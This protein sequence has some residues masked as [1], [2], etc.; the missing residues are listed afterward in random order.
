MPD[1]WEDSMKLNKY[2]PTDRNHYSSAGYTMLEE[3]LNSLC[4]E[5]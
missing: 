2:D 3:Y 5:M 4:P 1:E